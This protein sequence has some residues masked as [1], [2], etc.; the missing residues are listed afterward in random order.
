MIKK[1]LILVLQSYNFT[2]A[3][4]ASYIF[5]CHKD[6][7]LKACDALSSI[8]VALYDAMYTEAIRKEEQ[9]L[10]FSHENICILKL[11]VDIRKCL[12][13]GYL[14][15]VYKSNALVSCIYRIPDTTANEVFTLKIPKADAFL[16]NLQLD[17]YG[18]L[19]SDVTITGKKHTV[20]LN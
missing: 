14:R 10:L 7:F 8:I 2:I 1:S 5:M 15:K 19:L 20:T 3:R 6:G 17:S 9:D 12:K 4:D 11:M 18:N 13:N 16:N